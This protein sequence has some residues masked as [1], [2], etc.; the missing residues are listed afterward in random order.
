MTVSAADHTKFPT[1]RLA[2]LGAVARKARFLAWSRGRKRRCRAGLDLWLDSVHV[3]AAD[4]ISWRSPNVNIS[5]VSPR[6]AP[7]VLDNPITTC[8][9]HDENT[10]VKL[11]PTSGRIGDHT[12]LVTLE[13][14]L[15]AR[16]E[17]RSDGCVRTMLLLVSS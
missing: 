8:V 7:G 2:T 15:Y 14:A 13:N 11:R 9:P 1:S 16:G 4:S 17:E 10:V 3:D 5:I 6:R 12:R